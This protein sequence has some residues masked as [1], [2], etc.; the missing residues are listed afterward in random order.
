MTA[1][2]KDREIAMKATQ[3][4]WHR[5]EAPA[6]SVY[7]TFRDEQGRRNHHAVAET[8]VATIRD[9]AES[10]AEHIVRL[11]NRQPLY[12]A[13]VDAVRAL[14]AFPVID[15]DETEQIQAFD[16]VTDAL[17]ALEREDGDG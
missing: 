3:G 14:N 7:A 17:A 9:R 10:D 12:D 13:L 6:P 8:D 1:I 2:D 4:E 5:G 15:L 11:H 16:A